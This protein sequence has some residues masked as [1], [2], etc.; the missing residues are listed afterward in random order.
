M[1]DIFDMIKE[2]PSD[3]EIYNLA[4]GMVEITPSAT[5]RRIAAETVVE[6]TTSDSM[7]P[8]IHMYR[9]RLGDQVYRE[10]ILKL[11]HEHYKAP[12][13]CT[14]DMILATSGV[15]GAITS[16]LS[17]WRAVSEGSASGSKLRLGLFSPYYIYHAEIAQ[18]L[19][20]Q[21]GWE[22]TTIPLKADGRHDIPALDQQLSIYP[23]DCIITTNPGNPSG[24]SMT[25]EER[26]AWLGVI[27]NHPKTWFV[28]DEVYADMVYEGEFVSFQAPYP[29]NL[30]VARGFSKTL[31]VGSWRLAYV[32]S[33]PDRRQDIAREHDRMFLCANWSQLALGRYLKTETDDYLDFIDHWRKRLVHNKQVI[34]DAFMR[35][36]GWPTRP[37]E[38]SMYLLIDHDEA[39]GD[40]A[41]FA[42]VLE[43]C[44]VATAPGSIFAADQGTLRI[45]LAFE[46]AKADAIAERI[47]SS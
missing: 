45:Q 33:H 4:A 37:C 14:D 40:W 31:A 1:R 19:Y 29:K 39:G 20:G 11:C 17:A 5:L 38:G 21:D 36:F 7:I 43:T 34:S 28:F 18:T 27:A 32:L 15:S 46:E 3:V 22:Q 16:I 10:G 47:L 35:R 9:D 13:N 25:L 2:T 42:K 24:R 8:I 23:V 12:V 44:K 30:F 41:A 6:A 26:D